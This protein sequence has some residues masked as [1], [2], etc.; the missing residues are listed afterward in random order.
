MF[1]AWTRG[2]SSLWASHR[3]ELT[4][5]CTSKARDLKVLLLE[6]LRS[7]ENWTPLMMDIWALNT[8][9][10][11]TAPTHRSVGD[12][13]NNNN[14]MMMMIRTITVIT[15][16]WV[17]QPTCPVQADPGEHSQSDAAEQ[18]QRGDHAEEELQGWQAAR[19]CCSNPIIDWSASRHWWSQKQP[20]SSCPGVFDWLV[21]VSL[22]TVCPSGLCSAFIEL[23]MINY[24][25]SIP[26]QIIIRITGNQSSC[27][28]YCGRGSDQT[29]S[30]TW[31]VISE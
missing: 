20:D 21:W 3:P 29:P 13:D 8:T 22:V 19:H 7:S 17:E 2:V 6:L 31:K 9:G 18:Q 25:L 24:S 4:S 23:K 15:L 14:N 11:G 16:V 10:S 1:P 30:S 28:C 5:C 26:Q 12:G 27:S